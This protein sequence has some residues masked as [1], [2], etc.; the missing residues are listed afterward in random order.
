MKILL[1]AFQ[2]Q[3]VSQVNTG[4]TNIQHV[5]HVK[6]ESTMTNPIKKLVKP[7]PLAQYQIQQQP[8]EVVQM[9][10]LLVKEDVYCAELVNQ[11]YSMVLVL[12][13]HHHGQLENAIL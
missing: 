13:L 12:T 1:S 9:A 4:I 6:K 3:F 8:V 7:A 11:E 10:I 2:F 5:L